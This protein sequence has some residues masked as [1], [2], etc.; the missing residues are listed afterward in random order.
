[1]HKQF[2]FRRH[3]AIAGLLALSLALPGIAAALLK[4]DAAN[5]SIAAVFKQM[6][7]P[8][9]AKFKRPPGMVVKRAVTASKG[10]LHQPS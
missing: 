8:V 2:E 6:G 9:E 4:T 3:A 1:M 10:A 5:S 7:V